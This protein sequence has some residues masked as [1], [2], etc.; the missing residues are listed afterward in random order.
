MGSKKKRNRACV[1]CGKV[2][3]VTDEHVP[4][5]CLFA[6]D[7]RKDLVKV[8]ACADCNVGFSNDDEYFKVA[9]ALRDDVYEHPDVKAIIP[10]ILRA[11]QKPEKAGFRASFLKGFHEA[12]PRTA[13]GLMLPKRGAY[14]V[15]PIRLDRVTARIT[16]GLYYHHRGQRLPATHEAFGFSP[17]R[18]ANID[19]ENYEMLKRT[20]FDP[21]GLASNIMI[22]RRV[23]YYKFRFAEDDPDASVWLYLFYRRVP[24][25]GMTL[26]RDQA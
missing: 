19:P 8:P 15:N 20:M 22:G 4:P 17:P 10:S 26:R 23:F 2:G 25:V 6:E 7:D 13:S 5:E 9:L 24:F 14:S 12:Y 11:L 16:K 3:R 21:V 18:L 1:Y